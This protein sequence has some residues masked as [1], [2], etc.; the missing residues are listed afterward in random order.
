M[1]RR[2]ALIAVIA[3]VAITALTTGRARALDEADRLWFVGTQALNDHLVPLALQSLEQF[4]QNFP[5]DARA[6]QA[7]MLI[8]RTRLALGEYEPALAAF[9]RAQKASPPPGLPYEARFWEAETLMRLERYGEARAVYDDVV[10]GNKSAPFAPDALYGYGWTEFQMKRTE[11]AA[12]AFRDFVRAWPEHQLAPSA[13]YQLGRALVELKKYDDAVPV[14]SALET[15]YPTFK[16]A[17]DAQYLLGWSRMRSGDMKGGLADLKTFV[18]RY[19]S[20]ALVPDAKKLVTDAA[21]RVGDRNDLAQAYVALMKATPATAENLIEA[22]S[23]AN[24]LGRPRDEEAAW[25]K[26]NVEFPDHPLTAKLAFNLATAAF[27]R[28]EWSQA[29]TFAEAA[30]RTDDAAIRAEAWM[31][32]GES[33]LKIKRFAPAAKALEAAANERGAPALRDRALAALGLAREGQKDLRAALR[34]YDSVVSDSRDA[35]LRDWARERADALRAR[36][37]A[38]TDSPSAMPRTP[39]TTPRAPSAMRRSGS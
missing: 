17:A 4:V 8:G 15:K 21:V 16:F 10:R 37:E 33:D 20:H 30:A 34:A 7:Q 11:R 27:Q 22:A 24:K 13:T 14:L 2:L 23:V 1:T 39:S 5:N 12:N 19:P 9:R 28:K 29:A 6:P 35:D 25:R 18:A 31:L 32:A 26:L 36:L 38:A 3:L